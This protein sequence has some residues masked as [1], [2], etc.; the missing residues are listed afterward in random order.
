MKRSIKDLNASLRNADLR[1]VDTGAALRA[2]SFIV[3]TVNTAFSAPGVIVFVV[4]VV[5]GVG[6]IGH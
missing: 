2:Q 1:K 5:F 6:V 3:R 4:G